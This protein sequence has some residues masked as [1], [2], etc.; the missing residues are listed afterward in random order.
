MLMRR[1]AKLVT[2]FDIQ[3]IIHVMEM[4]LKV[5]EGVMKPAHRCELFLGGRPQPSPFRLVG[6]LVNKIARRF[7]LM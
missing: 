6:D 5:G 3:R 2:E 1:D 4:W 7:F